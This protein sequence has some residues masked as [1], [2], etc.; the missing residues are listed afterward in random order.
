MCRRLADAFRESC[1]RRRLHACLLC[2]RAAAACRRRRRRRLGHATAL[3]HGRLLGRV[4]AAWRLAS[5]AGRLNA[6]LGAVW[7]L[8][9]A[10]E[11]V[12]QE[13]QRKMEQVGARLPP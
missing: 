2:W 5:M 1:D 3:L 7:Q 8:Q 4:V 13:L 10:V 6:A 9:G 11:G 12:R